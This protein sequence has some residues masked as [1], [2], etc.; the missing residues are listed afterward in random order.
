MES[1]DYQHAYTVQIK[2]GMHYGSTCLISGNNSLI[3]DRF[4]AG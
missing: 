1:V 4:E 2:S 3:P